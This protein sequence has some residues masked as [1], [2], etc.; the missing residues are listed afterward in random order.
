M[1]A[2]K[3]TAAPASAPAPA[4]TPKPRNPHAEQQWPFNQGYHN[5]HAKLIQAAHGAATVAA[6]LHADFQIATDRA[7][8]D[9]PEDEPQPFDDNVISG[10]HLAL[11]VCLGELVAIGKHLERFR[12]VHKE[13][14]P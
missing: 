5:L 6:L 8:S 13:A 2:A 3:T 4:P 9:T 10:L 11:S 12:L 7:D 1:S 14:R